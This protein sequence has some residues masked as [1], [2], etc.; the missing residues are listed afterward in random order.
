MVKKRRRGGS[1]SLQLSL[2]E[3]SNQFD[4]SDNS[5]LSKEI[6]IDF[7][8]VTENESDNSERSHQRLMTSIDVSIVSN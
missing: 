7:E 6:D 2:F 8:D 3:L 4:K 5:E 1:D